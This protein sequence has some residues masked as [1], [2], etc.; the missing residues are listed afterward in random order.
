MRAVSAEKEFTPYAVDAFEQAAS[1]HGG[2][3]DSQCI[4]CQVAAEGAFAS[5]MRRW[6]WFVYELMVD[7]MSGRQTI[8]RNG[9]CVRNHVHQTRSVAEQQLLRVRF[10][11]FTGAVTLKP[12][13]GNYILLHNP[14]MVSAVATYWLQNSSIETVFSGYRQDIERILH[15]RHGIAHGT[16]HAGSQCQAAL[17]IYDPLTP[18][19]TVGQFMT[20]R[21]GDGV[22]TWLEH[23]L[24]LL[25]QW[26]AE[27]SP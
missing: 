12:N 18:Y 15:V 14:A 4:G 21:T 5:T 22:T 11:P 24:S 17:L 7:L 2:R 13:P 16:S 27:L 25:V 6:E 3:I 1:H 26:A 20:A 23:L 10:N 19:Q 8:H 9:S